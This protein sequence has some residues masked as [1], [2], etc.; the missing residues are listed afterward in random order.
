VAVVTPPAQSEWTLYRDRTGRNA[1]SWRV[2]HEDAAGR[3]AFN[4]SSSIREVVV[5]VPM[6][7]RERLRE[8]LEELAGW[9]A[10]ARVH[11]GVE[12]CAGPGQSWTVWDQIQHGL[13]E[14]AEAAYAVLEGR[15]LPAA[16][17]EA[18]G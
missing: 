10:K 9:A 2:A 12:Q 8:A 13:E 3:I 5:V 18:G 15:P 1:G 6:A 4:G 7:E 14:A 16:G 17:Q 11:H